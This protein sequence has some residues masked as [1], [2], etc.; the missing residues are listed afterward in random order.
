MKTA[1]SQSQF[2]R[3]KRCRGKDMQNCAWIALLRH[4]P[5]DQQ[6]RFMLVTASGTEIAIQSFLLIEGEF[7]AVKGRLSGT[8]ETGR[9]FFIPYAHIDYFGFSQAI[10]DSE[11]T[12]MFGTLE[13]PAPAPVLSFEATN[14]HTA[15]PGPAALP[16]EREPT[17]VSSPSRPSIRSEVLERFRSRGSAQ[18]SV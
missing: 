7:V 18:G 1:S 11:F 15:A 16:P 2:L 13:V 3:V 17:P 4:I 5:P 12:E 14:G 9:V 6:G 10:K 8:Q